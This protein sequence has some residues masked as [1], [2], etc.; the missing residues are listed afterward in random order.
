MEIYKVLVIFGLV[1]ITIPEP[2]TSKD[3]ENVTQQ[4]ALQYKPSMDLNPPHQLDT[5]EVVRM[6]TER[7]MEVNVTTLGFTTASTEQEAHTSTSDVT[8]NSSEIWTELVFM[9]TENSLSVTQ[10]KPGEETQEKIEAAESLKEADRLTVM[11]VS[12]S[13]TSSI[14]ETSTLSSRVTTVLNIIGKAVIRNDTLKVTNELADSRTKEKTGPK[15]TP[16][17]KHHDTKFIRKLSNLASFTT[18]DLSI[19]TLNNKV[20]NKVKEPETDGG[21]SLDDSPNN[22]GITLSPLVKL[23]HTNHADNTTLSSEI[24]GELN[25]TTKD[26]MPRVLWA[27]EAQNNTRSENRSINEA[28]VLPENI[29]PPVKARLGGIIKQL[30]STTEPFTQ[31]KKN[32]NHSPVIYAKD[33]GKQMSSTTG[34]SNLSRLNHFN[35]N[36]T[37]VNQLVKLVLLSP[38]KETKWEVMEAGR[39]HSEKAPIVNMASLKAS[40]VQEW[41]AAVDWEEEANAMGLHLSSNQLG[42]KGG[43]PLHMI[44]LLGIV[45]LVIFSLVTLSVLWRT[46]DYR[47]VTRNLLPLTHYDRTRR[48]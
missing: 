23:L 38:E 46:R 48:Y 8:N 1:F 47:Q 39:N 33:G 24:T 41:A 19:T 2:T 17:P 43:T 32:G 10:D 42:K 12:R 15:T 5:S 25:I 16:L 28:Y 37:G 18:M 21:N 44:V 45:T 9:A 36:E 4:T 26:T 29:G 35:V 13:I 31:G 7:N 27:I 11:S 40:I 30:Y 6:A 22:S 34:Q 14:N 20:E 3:V